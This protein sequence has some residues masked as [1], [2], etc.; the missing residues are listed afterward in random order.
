MIEKWVRAVCSHCGE[1]FTYASRTGWPHTGRS[2]QSKDTECP[3]KPIIMETELRVYAHNSADY[4]IF[5]TES[6]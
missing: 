1:S 5:G 6:C 3:G 4:Y 2:D